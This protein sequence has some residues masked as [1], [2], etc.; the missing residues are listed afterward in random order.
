MIWNEIGRNVIR[1]S[2]QRCEEGGPGG[3]GG[4]EEGGGTRGGGTRIR[5]GGRRRRGGGGDNGDRWRREEGFCLL[6]S[7]RKRDNLSRPNDRGMKGNGRE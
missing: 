1:W 7:I 4:G 5:G 2:G 3:G 6:P